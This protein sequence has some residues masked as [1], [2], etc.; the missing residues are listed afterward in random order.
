MNPR[1]VVVLRRRSDALLP[2]WSAYSIWC[3]GE[4]FQWLSVPFGDDGNRAPSGKARDRVAWWSAALRLR[5]RAKR[6]LKVHLV[7]IPKY[8]KQV[9]TGSVAC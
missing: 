5:A 9:L 8:R 4:C 6:D 1:M 7:W 3:D 2:N